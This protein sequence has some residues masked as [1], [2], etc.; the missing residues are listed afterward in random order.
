MRLADAI[1]A[2]AERIRAIRVGGPLHDIG[3]LALDRAILRKPGPLDADELDEIRTH[4]AARRELLDGDDV[5]PEALDCVLHHH[6]RWDGAATRTARRRRSR[7]RRGSSR[8]RTRTT[9]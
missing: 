5:A 3:K 8:S 4:P 6:E 2:A 7:S 9:R 1:G